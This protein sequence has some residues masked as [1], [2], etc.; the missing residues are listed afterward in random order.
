MLDGTTVSAAFEGA[1][2]RERFIEYLSVQLPPAPHPGDMM[3][4]DILVPHK[5]HGA[6]GILRK[7]GAALLYLPPHSP[8]LNPIEQTWSK[9][10]AC[11]QRVLAHRGTTDGGPSRF[12]TTFCTPFFGFVHICRLFLLFIHTALVK[13]IL[14]FI[15]GTICDARHKNHLF[16]TNS[17]Y[18]GENV[19][20]DIPTDG[21]AAFKSELAATHFDLLLPE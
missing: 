9:M 21:S 16:G 1:A 3:V 10:N 15:D 6:D 12:Y 4:M 2:D 7:A 8:V 11:L 19:L 20:H 14:A 17:F 18:P 13:A 5:A